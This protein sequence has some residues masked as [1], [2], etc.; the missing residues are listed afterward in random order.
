M[1]NY[2]ILTLYNIDIIIYNYIKNMPISNFFPS[3]Y[4][5]I[6]IYVMLMLINSFFLTFQ[7]LYSLSDIF[8]SMATIF[9]KLLQMQWCG[10]QQ[11]WRSFYFAPVRYRNSTHAH[12]THVHTLIRDLLSRRSKTQSSL[13]TIMFTWQGRLQYI[14]T[15]VLHRNF[16]W[17]NRVTTFKIVIIT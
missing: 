9:N 3:M 12:L 5:G 11:T 13:H 7:P 6:K 2:I 17:N 8:P 16:C 15:H 10:E 14:Q 4:K 1:Y